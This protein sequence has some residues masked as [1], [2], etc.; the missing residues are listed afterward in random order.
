[1]SFNQVVDS[2]I[3]VD[4]DEEFKVIRLVDQWHG[5]IPPTRWGS[6]Y[7]RKFNAKLIP[8]LVRIPKDKKIL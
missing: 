7:L 2:I 4:F 8:W 6:A 1:M 3:V 5:E